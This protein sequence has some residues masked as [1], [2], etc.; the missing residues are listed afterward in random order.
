MS[1][2]LYK[3]KSPIQYGEEFIDNYLAHHTIEDFE[4]H[5]VSNYIKGVF[6][7][8]IDKICQQNKNEKYDKFIKDWLL[9]VL[10]KDTKKLNR[11][12][13]HFWLSLD[14]LDFRQVGLLLFRQYEETGDKRYLESIGEL[15]ET[16]FTSYPKTNN[17]ILW[18]NKQNAPYQ[19]WVDGLYMAGPICAGYAKMSGKEEFG[20]HAIKQAVL[21]YEKLRDEKD[22]LLFHGWDESK[23]AEWADPVTG[24]SAEK[25][26]RA[27]GWFV[28]ACTEMIGYLGDDFEGIDKVKDYLKQVLEALLKVQRTED[29]Y[30]SQIVDKPY[31]EGNWRESSCT[32]LITY[33]L[34]KAY[35]L[36]IVGEE[37]IEAAKKA[38]E[39]II[40]SLYIDE[41]GNKILD[42]V[43]IGTCI[44]DGDYNHYKSR[45]KV[46]ND[47]HGTGAFLQMC[48]EMNL[49]D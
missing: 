22:G 28:V 45:A 40:D 23:E 26:G 43:C 8:G 34:A 39:G 5:G 25:W 31:A 20:H 29:G 2:Y 17:G 36:G 48:A 1:K 4:P 3:G 16:L 11:E 44:D 35:R 41:N 37:Y 15:C 30:W 10:D 42:E 38:F 14:S 24:L 49:V 32:C 47:L 9:K 13:G 21:M 6:M 33:A 18:H 19:V 27:L 7:V 12:E 46:K